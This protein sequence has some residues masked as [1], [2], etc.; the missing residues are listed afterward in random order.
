MQRCWQAR[1]RAHRKQFLSRA[2]LCSISKL[3]TRGYPAAP[4]AVIA[5]PEAL[6]S[7]FYAITGQPV[8][9]NLPH[10]R[11][12]G[13]A[14]YR[15][16][17]RSGTRHARIIPKKRWNCVLQAYYVMISGAFN[18]VKTAVL[19]ARFLAYRERMG[20]PA[21][22]RIYFLDTSKRAGLTFT[23]V[24]MFLIPFYFGLLFAVQP[25]KR[26]RG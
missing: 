20:L 24:L 16:I 10:A 11:L 22:T 1:K 26:A 7:D 18:E 5:Q 4:N 21:G 19:M 12:R 23:S 13:A 3:A 6:A 15:P 14:C 8:L 25:V 9:G 2:W 17:K